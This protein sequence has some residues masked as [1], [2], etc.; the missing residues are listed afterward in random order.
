VCISNSNSTSTTPTTNSVTSV[1]TSLNNTHTLSNTSSS[2][3][4]TVT[5]SDPQRFNDYV[6]YRV[7]TRVLFNFKMKIW[8]LHFRISLHREKQRHSQS[9]EEMLLTE[10]LSFM[11]WKCVG[12]WKLDKSS[13]IQM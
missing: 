13:T 6:A 7:T 1:D 5:V 12:C 2:F 11:L 4:L 3:Y 10:T 8:C 9:N